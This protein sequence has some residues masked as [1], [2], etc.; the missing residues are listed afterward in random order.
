MSKCY[1]IDI[2]YKNGM[3]FVKCSEAVTL[4]ITCLLEF[5]YRKLHP[6]TRNESTEGE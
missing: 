5:V 6:I 4:R 3:S 1:D 2:Q